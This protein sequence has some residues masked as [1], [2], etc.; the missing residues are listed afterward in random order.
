MIEGF[1]K[2]LKPKLIKQMALLMS[3]C[4]LVS[5]LQEHISM[6]LHEVFHG[7]EM[8]TSLLSHTTYEQS[9][10][11]VH[12]Q[13]EHEYV[14]LEHEHPFIDLVNTVLDAS[15][16]NHGSEEVPF[17]KVKLKKHITSDILVIPTKFKKEFAGEFFT[18]KMELNT[19][20]PKELDAPPKSSI[21]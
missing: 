6:V 8:P 3:I 16:E 12:E 14:S 11:Q 21:Q 5:P 19:G 1:T 13:H 9:S 4:Y 17:N 15:N 10:M 18:L 2:G 7:L 20:H